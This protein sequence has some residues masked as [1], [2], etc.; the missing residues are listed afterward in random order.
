MDTRFS[1]GQRSYYGPKDGLSRRAAFPR[2]AKVVGRAAT[3]L[4]YKREV[5]GKENLPKESGYVLSPNHENTFDPIVWMDMTRGDV[6]E[7]VTIEVFEN[8]LSGA[9]AR[10]NGA[11]PVDRFEPNPVTLK[12]S[13]DVIANGASEVIYPQGGFPGGN[14]IGGIYKGAAYAALKGGGKGVVPIG[15]HIEESKAR[16]KSWKDRLVGAAVAGAVGLTAL[17]GAPLVAA[18]IAGASSAAIVSGKLARKAV[19]QKEAHDP[20]PNLLSGVVGGAAGSLGGAA[21]AVGAVAAAPILAIPMVVAAGVGGAAISRAVRRRPV[22]QVSI[23]KPLLTRD[24]SADSDGVTRMTEDLHESL[25]Q[26]K[27]RLSGEAI[28]RSLPVFRTTPWT[29]AENLAAGQN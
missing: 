21:L 7:M 9:A 4:V 26:A 11:F 25:A 16:K 1:P 6:R 27:S 22:A 23:Q 20:I 24:Y 14:Q 17:A 13:V 18:G 5:E 29:P 15:I 2:L 3:G 12:H 10:L 8:P 28:D 19:P